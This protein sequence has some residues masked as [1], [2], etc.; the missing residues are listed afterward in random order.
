[1]KLVKKYTLILG[2]AVMAILAVIAWIRGEY[3]GREFEADLRRDH[4]TASS[5]TTRAGST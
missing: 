3:N 2:L 5:S 4:Q 1:M